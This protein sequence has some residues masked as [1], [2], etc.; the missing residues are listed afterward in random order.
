MH[1]KI[2]VWL[3]TAYYTCTEDIIIIMNLLYMYIVVYV[4]KINYICIY[5]VFE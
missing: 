2:H 1:Q 4:T 5:H 3:K